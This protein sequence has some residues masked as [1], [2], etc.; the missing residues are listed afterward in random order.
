MTKFLFFAI[1]VTSLLFRV[2]NLNLIEFK[3]DEAINLL[4]AARPALGYEVTSGGTLSSLGILNPPLFNYI[5]MPFTYFTLDPRFF[6]FLIGFVNSLAIAFLFLIIKKFYGLRISLISSVLLA[7]SP[8]AIIYSRKIWTQDL[9][10]PFFIPVFYSF[11]KLLIEKKQIFWIPYVAFSFF[12]M[13]LHQIIFIFIGTLSFFMIFQ[14]VKIDIKYILIGTIIGI[15]PLLPF[16]FFEIKNNCPDCKSI[17]A[18][19]NRLSSQRSLNLFFQPLQIASQGNFRFILGNDTLVF[20]QKFP[21]VERLRKIFYFE[22][23]LIPLGIFLFIKKFSKLRALAY[24]SI[25]LP[26][27][28]Y[29]LKIEPFMHY[30]IILIPF[31]F[32]FLGV[33]FDYLFERKNLLIKFGSLIIFILIIFESIGFNLSFFKLLS[34]QNYLSGDYGSSYQN[35]N[36]ETEK[37]LISFK[38]Q[39]D[40]NEIKLS[41]HIPLGYMYGYM[42][43]AKIIYPEKQNKQRIEYLENELKKGSADPRIPQELFA[44]Y[45]QNKTTL[46]SAEILRK[47]SIEIKQYEPI[48]NLIFENYLAENFK[49]EY[50]DVINGYRFLYPRHWKAFSKKGEEIFKGDGI[51]ITFKG[52]NLN[53]KMTVICKK[54][55]GGICS[56]KNLEI[57]D[58]IKSTIRFL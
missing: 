43:F 21:F 3:T 15:I 55:D 17:I 24:C 5:L 28:Y 18:S 16:V 36:S 58:Q 11:H 30:Y 38:N 49:N 51:I 34:E 47:K 25:L 45:T 20:S 54:E 52:S 22:Y 6:S 12:L 31:V 4:L 56:K 33:A 46:E 8:W 2:T 9:L 48:Y 44:I 7:F 26:T 13:Q 10:I 29:F 39:P 41:N 42:P 57:A 23:F 19:R 27:T 1:L 40:Y 50:K 53:E 14:K 35:I 32:I 37:K